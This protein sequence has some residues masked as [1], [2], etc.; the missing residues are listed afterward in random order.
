M[1]GRAFV[2]WY[3]HL[4]EVRDHDELDAALNQAAANRSGDVPCTAHLFRAN[5]GSLSVGAAPDYAILSFTPADG[6]PPYYATVGDRDAQRDFDQAATTR[7]DRAT[8]R[9]RR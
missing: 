1:P 5:A 7:Y 3:E 6:E 9:L 8:A 2:E 4:V